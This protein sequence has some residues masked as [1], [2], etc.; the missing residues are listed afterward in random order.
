MVVAVLFLPES[1]RWYMSKGR[2]DEARAFLLK[3][4]ANGAEWDPL[5][6][7][8]M[9]EI[10]EDSSTAPVFFVSHPARPHREPD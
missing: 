8:E 3:Y 4:H 6:D 7:F 2:T 5:V 9:Q 1:P 10:R